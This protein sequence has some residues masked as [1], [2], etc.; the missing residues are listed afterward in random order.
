MTGTG[1]SSSEILGWGQG[2]A[3]SARLQRESSASWSFTDNG[4]QAGDILIFEV[5][6]FQDTGGTGANVLHLSI[7]WDILE[8]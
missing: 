7:I 1:N 8:F 4:V 5:Q 6:N 3:S 2:G